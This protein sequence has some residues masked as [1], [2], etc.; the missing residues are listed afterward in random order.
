MDLAQLAHSLVTREQLVEAARSWVGTP[1]RHQGQLKGV[2]A[3]CKGMVVGTAVDL[4]LPEARSLAALNMSYSKG[5]S[6]KALHDGL[7]Q[8]LI[9]VDEPQPGDVLAILFGRDPWPVHLAI[10]TEPGSII[11]AYFGARFV[12]EVPIGHLRV[13]S[14]WTWPSLGGVIG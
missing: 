12:A 6:G 11:H 1:T 9:R 5:F 14:S 8:T 3:D 13:H 10:L 4:N 2:A 7:A